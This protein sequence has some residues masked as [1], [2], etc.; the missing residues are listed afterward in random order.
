MHVKICYH[1]I[2]SNKDKSK[3]KLGAYRKNNGTTVNNITKPKKNE[4]F[5]CLFCSVTLKSLYKL[6][7]YKEQMHIKEKLFYCSDSQKKPRD[8]Q[9][10][11]QTS[12]CPGSDKAIFT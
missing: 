9:R 8:H 11:H 7:K 10:S 4:S 1:V 5:V 12:A 2:I 3:E 6:E